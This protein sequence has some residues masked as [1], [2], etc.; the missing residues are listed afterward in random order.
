M[1]S[2]RLDVIFSKKSCTC[3]RFLKRPLEAFRH[4]VDRLGW[5]GVTNFVGSFLVAIAAGFIIEFAV[6]FALRKWR[7]HEVVPEDTEESLPEILMR[8]GLRLFRQVV[9]IIAFLIVTRIVGGAL[10]EAQEGEL[11]ELVFLYGIVIPRLGSALLRFFLEPDNASLRLISTDDDTARM[12]YRNLTGILYFMGFGLVLVN[13]IL[14]NVSAPEQ[15]AGVGFWINLTIFVWLGAVVYHSRD[16]LQAITRG[17]QQEEE[18]T[19][20]ENKVSKAY[21]W[22][23]ISLIAGSWLLFEFIAATGR[24]YLLIGGKHFLTLA[25]L[26]LAPALDT[27][28]RAV[29]EEFTRPMSGEGEIAERAYA[30]T[31]RSYVR[32][33]RVLVFGTVILLIARLW[34]LDLADLSGDE[35]GEWFAAKLFT[36]IMILTCGYLVWEIATLLFNRQLAQ[37][38][39]RSGALAANMH[40]GP[41]MIANPSRL[42]TVL[43]LLRITTQATI[44]VMTILVALSNLGINIAPLIAGAGV[45]GLAIGFGAQTLVRDVVSGLFFLIDDAFRVG[46]YIVIGDIAGTVE[47][48]SIRSLQ[49][50]H[51]QGAVHTIP[52]GGIT[53]V[54]NNSRDWA[55]MK[56]KFIVPFDTDI[57]KVRKIFKKIGAEIMEEPYAEDL[58][59]TFKSQGVANVDDVGL[60]IRGKFMAKPGKQWVIRKDIYAR[61]QKA[62]AENGIQFARR[63]VRVVIPDQDEADEL[64]EE[65]REAIAGAAIEAANAAQNAAPQPAKVDSR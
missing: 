55:I 8:L 62:F 51:H 58:I 34:N 13:F 65:T 3:R 56:L 49:L 54:T 61:V 35:T 39:V 59:E 2:R 21:P 4:F 26:L 7:A 45:V 30:S 25:I 15:G 63:E 1:I 64:N 9:G 11:A 31:K 43:P 23:A 60:S 16:G 38:S 18:L 48:I 44:I 10:L 33:G 53:R 50:R 17:P 32:I 37:I 57:E 36:F 46:E 19:P 42:G 12:L 5:D 41:S 28:I 52:Y 22:Y 14:M 20:V 24:G 27:M 47:K 40:Q 29:V 6:N